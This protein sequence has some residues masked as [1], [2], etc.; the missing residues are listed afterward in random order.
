MVN[1]KVL[2][3]VDDENTCQDCRRPKHSCKIFCQERALA[4][5]ESSIF[6]ITIHDFGPTLCSQ[7]W[8]ATM[9]IKTVL[10]SEGSCNWNIPHSSSSA[11]TPSSDWYP[12]C[13]YRAYSAG[14]PPKTK[15]K[16]F[17]A[18]ETS[19]KLIES[20][21][22]KYVSRRLYIVSCCRLLPAGAPWENMPIRCAASCACTLVGF[23]S[24]SYQDLV[25]RST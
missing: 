2:K 16:T 1:F 9:S 24:T 10:R 17:W 7:M 4:E 22:N 3:S 12:S 5:K 20:V 8:R 23:S 15:E 25:W 6:N 13:R 14:N 18:A 11:K 21:L 19:G